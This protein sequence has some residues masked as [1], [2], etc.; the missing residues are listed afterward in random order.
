MTPRTDIRLSFNFGT[1][2]LQA[3]EFTDADLRA[4]AEEFAR[5]THANER[6]R[7]GKMYVHKAVAM[8]EHEDGR[9]EKGLMQSALFDTDKSNGKQELKELLDAV[10]ET[11][12][13]KMYEGRIVT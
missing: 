2:Q 5:L 7:E 11:V 1:V 12:M 6:C 10:K 13:E 4:P 3:A 8:L 9:M